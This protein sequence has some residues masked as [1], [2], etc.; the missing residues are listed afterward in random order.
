MR[1]LVIED[2]K[3]LRESLAQYFSE[4]SFIVDSSGTG[5][6]GLWYASEHPYDVI[7]LDLMLPNIDGMEILKNLRKKQISVFI[8][9]ISARDG[10]E[11]RTR[12]TQRGC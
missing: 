7:L 5:D 6:E 8:L 12:S 2:H 10:L 11:D 1:L 4:A 3:S 9:V